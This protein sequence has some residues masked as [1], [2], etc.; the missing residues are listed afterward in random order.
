MPQKLLFRT[1]HGSHLYGLET[2]ASD[3]D[4]KAVVLPS[5]ADVLL[6]GPV[7]HIV[8]STG[9]SHSRNTKDDVD[10][11]FMSLRKFVNLAADGEMICIDMLWA[12]PQAVL[13]EDPVF[14]RLRQKRHSFIS[15][16]MA[17]YMKYVRGQV[18]KYG[19]KGSRYDVYVRAVEW[20]QTRV[21]S[22]SHAKLGEVALE[23]EFPVD[24]D[25]MSVESIPAGPSN[26]TV[27]K[28]LGKNYTFTT[29]ATV[30]LDQLKKALEGMG[31]RAQAAAA[32]NGV[33]WKA[34]SHAFRACY[35]LEQIFTRG[36]IVF[37]FEG[38][39]KEFLLNVKTG[40]MNFKDLSPMLDDHMARVTE[41]SEASSLP[42]F[43]LKDEIDAIYLNAAYELYKL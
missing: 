8:D 7:T 34:V 11:E 13:V 23:T 5:L 18:N 9:Q 6:S 4:Y 35:Q 36:E 39:T 24:G 16:D 40:Q 14:Y 15:K 21:S 19:F 33:D 41:L 38:P 27:W 1:I 31:A 2:P 42:P 32:N 20:L 28:V 22:S 26:V 43:V 10:N 37:P 3:R 29:R 30:I 12:S 25:L 17:A